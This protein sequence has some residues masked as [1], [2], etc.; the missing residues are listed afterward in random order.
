MSI[1]LPK[2]VGVAIVDDQQLFLDGI[3]ALLNA[4][5]ELEVVA[6]AMSGAQALSLFEQRCP[7]IVL[8]DLSMPERDGMEVLNDLKAHFPEIKV[9][10]LTVHDDLPSIQECLRRGAM[11]YVLKINGKD[12]LL[13]AILE[14]AGGRK[15]LDPKVLDTLIG[16]EKP[17]A[18]DGQKTL[19][20]S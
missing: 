2:P 17:P 9:I 19:S 7:E 12:E 18:G 10:M 3:S 16:H 15:Y 20:G 6:A 5:P 8:L 4:C 13:H 1:A 11:G 14:V